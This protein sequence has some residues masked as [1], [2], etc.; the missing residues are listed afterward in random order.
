MKK[1]LILYRTQEEHAANAERFECGWCH[2]EFELGMNI[3]ANFCP[4]CGTEF[5][6]QHDR[7]GEQ[8]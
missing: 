5:E 6:S 8:S 1:E 3:A 2:E 4:E 7:L